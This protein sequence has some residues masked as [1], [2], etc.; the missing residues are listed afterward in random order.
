MSIETELSKIEQITKWRTS[1][2][3]EFYVLSSA[4]DHALDIERA[5]K[6]NAILDE[7]GS[8]ADALRAMGAQYEINPILERVTKATRLV[9]SHWQCRE[10]PGYRIQRISPNRIFYIYGNAGSW[11]GAYGGNVGLNDLIRYASD[12]RTDFGPSSRSTE[13]KDNGK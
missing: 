7:G 13:R 3:E 8:V 2:G 10:E 6:A 4:Q 9:I 1:D 11:S 5:Y 12:K